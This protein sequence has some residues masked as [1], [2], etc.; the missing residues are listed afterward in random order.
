MVPPNNHI[1]HWEE[2]TWQLAW[3]IFQRRQVGRKERKYIKRWGNHFNNSQTAQS[4]EKVHGEQA[5]QVNVDTVKR[6]C[7]NSC[8]LFRPHLA[9][10]VPSSLF[11]APHS[12]MTD[13]PEP[14][15]AGVPQPPVLWI[16]SELGENITQFSIFK[17]WNVT[18]LKALS[19]IV[20]MKLTELKNNNYVTSFTLGMEKVFHIFLIVLTHFWDSYYTC[21]T[22]REDGSVRVLLFSIY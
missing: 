19:W 21:F 22:G 18:R 2:P 1:K 11:P 6:S 15:T 4:P 14:F 3:W 16:V 8:G 10:P 7:R 13:T 17:F 5:L 20:W 9:L 12:L